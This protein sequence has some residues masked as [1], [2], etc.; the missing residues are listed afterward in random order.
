MNENFLTESDFNL[1]GKNDTNAHLRS[2]FKDKGDR[3]LFGDSQLM[4]DTMSKLVVAEEF[5]ASECENDEF[6][7]L[8]KNKETEANLSVEQEEL[9][10]MNYSIKDLNEKIRMTKKQ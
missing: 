9:F 4:T 3:N 10:W 5:P 7:A 8:P 2:Q 1:T 6:Y